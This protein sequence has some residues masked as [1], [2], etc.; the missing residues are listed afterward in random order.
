MKF[1]FHA[2]PNPMKVALMI[3]ELG[4]SPEVVPVDTRKGEQHT[5]EFLA[6][7]PNAKLPAVDDDGTIVFDSGAILLYL[8]QKHGRFLPEGDA[9]MGEML[10]W[11]FFVATGLSPFSG[12]AVHFTRVMPGEAYSANRYGK[13]VRRHY[14]VLDQRLGISPWVGGA[15]YTIADI[16]A[17]GWVRFA[18]VPLGEDGLAAYPNVTAWLDRVNARP[19]AGRAWSLMSRFEFK[20]EMDEAAKRA[21]FPQNY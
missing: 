19:A 12:Q 14:A 5:P 20:Q 17:W 11:F 10:S 6:I 9:A 15:D 16:A 1:F 18:F 4:L 8:A 13:E 21:M 7:N 3:E 2:T